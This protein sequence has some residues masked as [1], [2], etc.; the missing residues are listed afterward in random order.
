MTKHTVGLAYTLAQYKSF[1]VGVA[2]IV[3]SSGTIRA[4]RRI[5]ALLGRTNARG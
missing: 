4:P 2:K 1:P 3:L 5:C